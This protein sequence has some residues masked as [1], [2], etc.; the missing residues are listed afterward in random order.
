MSAAT[1]LVLHCV[2]PAKVVAVQDIQ[3]HTGRLIEIVNQYKAPSNMSTSSP[4]R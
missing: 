3:R 4:L 1:T 2:R